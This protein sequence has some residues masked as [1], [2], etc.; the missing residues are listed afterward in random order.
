MGTYYALA[1]GEPAEV[2]VAIREHYLPR[3]AGDELPETHAGL[4]VAIA[5][6][7]DTLAGIFEIGEKPTGAKDPFG[8]RRAAIGLLRIL[9][10]KRLD[11]DLRK[12]I[13]IALANVHADVERI[14]AAKVA[15]AGTPPA[16]AAPQAPAATTAASKHA[17]PSAAT[18]STTS[19]WNACAPTTW[20][21]KRAPRQA[22]PLAFTT[23]MF[24][25][26][27]ATKPELPAR[28]RRAAQGVARL[29][30][31]P[32][33]D[34]PRRCQQTH[35][36]HPAQSRRTATPR[37]RHRV[38]E[39][40]RRSP[41]VRRDARTERSRRH[42]PRSARIRQRPGPARAAAAAMSMPSSIR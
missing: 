18:R 20:N 36:Q 33:S 22:P 15:S 7:L 14:R 35:C 39:G 3:G 19:S 16:S 13:D 5:D 31:S 37:S 4:A 11:L 1:D 32:R 40:P 25:A 10:E 26:V 21:A 27:L 9:I 38:P 41:L 17:G 30:R 34:E 29:P 28:L 2:A 42:R 6:K 12:L 24:D 23:E 8:L